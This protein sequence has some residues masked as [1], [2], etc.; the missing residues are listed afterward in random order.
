M[1]ARLTAVALA[2][3]T[4]L[5]G[6]LMH[7]PAASAAPVDGLPGFYEAPAQLPPANGDL[8]RSE[9]MT[10]TLDPA[11]ATTV[12]F[13]SSRM[14]YRSTDRTGK[15]IAVSGSVI[16]PKKPWA[17]AGPRPVI[18][19]AVGTQG[20]GDACAPSRQ[21]SEGFEYEGVFMAG[22]LARGYALAVTDYEGLGTAGIHT[23]MDRASQGHA[24]LD[25]IRAAKQLPG[26]S[27]AAGAPAALYGYSQ[28]GGAAAAAAELAP[29][30][31][32]E[33]TLKGAVVGAVPA[34]LTVLPD[35]LDRGLWA[36]F[37]WFAIAGLTESY[38]VDLDPYL[39]ERGRAFYA[40]I[41]DDC[42]FDLFNAA[43]TSS[44]DFTTDGSSLAQLST[45]EPFRTILDDQRIGRRA[46]AVPV[47]VTHSVLDDT[48]PYRVG[49]QLARD[50]CDRGANVRL[51]TN[52]TPLH[53]GAMLNNAAEVYGYLEARF[54]GVPAASSC[55]RL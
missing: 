7:A 47:L 49:R 54:A 33:L 45:Q 36:E 18:G 29:T 35:N 44:T 17:G 26:S 46:P 21:F 40:D 51:S 2:G 34:D 38:D 23:Y 12:G 25:A 31:A 37:L 53:L 41:S 50:W 24:V 30:Y 16:V 52:V 9:P 3:T 32:P 15:P 11:G 55:W 10:Y 8:I 4:L 27:L 39:N 19:Y 48:I 22:L 6:S 13:T 20:V 5:A 14:L 42:V 1:F 28:G 43:L